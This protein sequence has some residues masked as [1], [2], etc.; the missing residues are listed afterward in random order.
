[1]NG[2]RITRLIACSEEGK[3]LRRGGPEDGKETTAKG[4]FGGG[5]M[6]LDGWDN[7]RSGIGRAVMFQV[8]GAAVPE[9]TKRLARL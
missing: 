1:L 3:G 5:V 9:R 2:T 8:G 4:G 6:C 7:A